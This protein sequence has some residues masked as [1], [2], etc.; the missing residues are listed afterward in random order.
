MLTTASS[1]LL[2]G[3]IRNVCISASRFSLKIL[4]TLGVLFLGIGAFFGKVNW[5]LAV[6]VGVG[7]AGIFGANQI[8]TVL[9]GTSE[10]CTA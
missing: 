10:C 9:G 2:V 4:A 5:G 3:G 6:M 8:V 7:I 1:R